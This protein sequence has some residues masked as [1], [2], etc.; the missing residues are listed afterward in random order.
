MKTTYLGVRLILSVN[1][2]TGLLQGVQVPDS[3]QDVMDVLSCDALK[4][5]HEVANKDYMDSHVE[6]YR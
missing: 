2:N 1:K 4:H 6:A 3:E 5:C